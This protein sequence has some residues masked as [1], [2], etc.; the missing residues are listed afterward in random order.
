[1]S[2]IRDVSVM[3]CW[4]ISMVVREDRCVMHWNFVV[5]WLS[6]MSIECAVCESE[7]LIKV[8]SISMSVM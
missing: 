7:I 1:M 8:I 3:I 6:M 2:T 5:H 4:Y